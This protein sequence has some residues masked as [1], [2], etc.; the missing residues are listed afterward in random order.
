MLGTSDGVS[1]QATGAV[2][3]IGKEDYSAWS[4][5]LMLTAPLN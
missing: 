4:G 5:R 2:E 1:F 3:G